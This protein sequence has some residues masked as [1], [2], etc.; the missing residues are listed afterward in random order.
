MRTSTLGW[1]LALGTAAAAGC[2]GSSGGDAPRPDGGGVDS[3]ALPDPDAGNVFTGGEA[4][5]CSNLTCNQVTCPTGQ[6]T[7]VS[8]TV[9]DPAGKVPLYNVVVY[10]PNAPLDPLPANGATCDQCGGTIS[11]SPIVTTLTDAKG[12]FVLQG[13]PAGTNVPLVMQLGKWRRK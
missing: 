3:G 5:G 6:K 12:E 2:S 9:Y 13:V 8:G 10:V 1:I 4:G 7:T 11:G